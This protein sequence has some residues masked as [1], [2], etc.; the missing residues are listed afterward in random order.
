MSQVANVT[1]SSGECYSLEWRMYSLGSECNSLEWR[2][3]P[4]GSKMKV[5]EWQDEQSQVANRTVLSGEMNS[6]R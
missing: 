2:M 6:L 4:L 5:F 1:F 3:Y